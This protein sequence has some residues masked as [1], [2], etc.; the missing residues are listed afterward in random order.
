MVF[1]WLF[2]YFC[3]P[4]L[5]FPGIFGWLGNEAFQAAKWAILVFLIT[6]VVSFLFHLIL[7]PVAFIFVPY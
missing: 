3:I 7:L 5:W 4:I 2:I 6:L 1:V